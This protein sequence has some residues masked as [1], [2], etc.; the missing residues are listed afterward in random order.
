MPFI[1]PKILVSIGLF[2]LIFGHVPNMPEILYTTALGSVQWSDII[3]II[4]F[5][6]LILIIMKS[7]KR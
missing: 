3:G 5:I 4:C 1:I 7:A 6:P 2:L